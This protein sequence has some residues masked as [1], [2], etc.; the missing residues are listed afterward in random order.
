V[1]V[2]ILGPLVGIGL[3]FAST[4]GEQRVLIVVAER[5]LT[6]HG[7]V[8]PDPSERSKSSYRRFQAELP[9]RSW[10]PSLRWAWP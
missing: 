5:I 8:V 1:T 4:E 10:R 9:R 3:G 6:R 7:A 2:G